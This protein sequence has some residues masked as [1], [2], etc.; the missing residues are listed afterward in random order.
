MATS[1]TCAARVFLILALTRSTAL[2]GQPQGPGPRT[3]AA[4]LTGTARIAGRVVD[5]A[6]GRPVARATV[7]LQGLPTSPPPVGTNEEG[8]F[9]FSDVPPCACALSVDK[10]G[11]LSS[12]YPDAPPTLRRSARGLTIG[13][14][15]VLEDLVVP[16]YR[17]GAISGRVVDAFGDPVESATVQVLRL[18]G[19][20]QGR[21]RNGTETDD[22]GEF[23]VPKLEP[24]RYLLFVAHRNRADDPN[25]AQPLP[26]FFP[27][28]LDASEALPIVVDRGQSVGGIDFA[29]LA[30]T[31]AWVEGAL[32]DE[33]GE[34]IESR[35]VT[36]NARRLGSGAVDYGQFPMEVSPDGTFRARL[37]PGEYELEARMG[38][39]AAGRQ[40]G[41]SADRVGTLRVTVSGTPLSDLALQLGPG[42]TLA[43][44]VV[45]EG[46]AP[47]DRG[48]VGEV[49][50]AALSAPQGA[51]CRRGGAEATRGR[52]V[53]VETDRDWTFRLPGLFG[54]C[55]LSLATANLGDWSVA[56]VYA[57]DT[58]ILDRPVS[59][60]SGQDLRD[61]RVVVSDRRTQIDLRVTDENGVPTREYVALL[62]SVDPARWHPA[63]G[64]VRPFQPSTRPSGP[65]QPSAVIGTSRATPD[66]LNDLPRGEYFAVALDDLP[67]ETVRNP[68]TLAQLAKS[69]TRLTVTAGANGSVTLA[70]LSFA[71]A[72]KR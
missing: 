34:R 66:R 39:R 45:F 49:L 7:R 3:P 32:L 54:T 63:S 47:P 35:R 40:P 13:A 38:P 67:A 9:A 21:P 8:V 10:A 17:G 58:D 4:P 46:V 41:E 29:L 2:A 62:F 70:R 30:G 42:V 37:P 26:T 52:R 25:E 72:M 18:S 57:G 20:G 6:T 1:G 53:A 51:R 59:F 23:R 5:A 12:R 27:G 16:L 68:E 24:G 22:R 55:I 65:A 31:T 33:E 43:G 15:T 28:V 69:A 61:V 14:G 44:R 71:D 19:D 56:A 50:V 64:S 36:A 60:D 11:F 48:S